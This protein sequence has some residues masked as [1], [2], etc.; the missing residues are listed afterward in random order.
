M[1]T[2]PIGEQLSIEVVERV[3]ENPLT[4]SSGCLLVQLRGAVI[5]ATQYTLSVGVGRL[6]TE[7]AR[8]VIDLTGVDDV[9]TA[10]LLTLL[11]EVRLARANGCVVV[12]AAPSPTVHDLLTASG[13][14]LNTRDAGASRVVEPGRSRRLGASADAGRRP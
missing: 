4:G 5:A 3:A 12:L 8:I 11:D 10:G 2:G 9:D 1:Q 6:L 14:A 7:R 13:L